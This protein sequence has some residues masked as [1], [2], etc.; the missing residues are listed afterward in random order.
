MVSSLGSE[1]DVKECLAIGAKSFL[2]K[3]FAK[4]T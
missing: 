3:P 2:R 4:E 1:D